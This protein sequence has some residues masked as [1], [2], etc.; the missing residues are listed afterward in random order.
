MTDED[1]ASYN[2]QILYA[3]SVESFDG[4]MPIDVVGCQLK[5]AVHPPFCTLHQNGITN[6]ED[7]YPSMVNNRLA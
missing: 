6:G 3:I 5:L 2:H 4:I 7:V 1:D